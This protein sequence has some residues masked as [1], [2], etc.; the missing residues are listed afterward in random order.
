MKFPDQGFWIR[1]WEGVRDWLRARPT[2]RDV[3]IG[4]LFGGLIEFVAVPIYF[5]DL[6]IVRHTGDDTV[7]RMTRSCPGNE[8]APGLSR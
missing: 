2:W 1:A 6:S 8:N 3:L 4:V 7:D 5:R